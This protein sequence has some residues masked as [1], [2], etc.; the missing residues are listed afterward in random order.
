MLSEQVK[1]KKKDN[2]KIKK[3]VQT[4][5]ACG[6]SRGL[7]IGQYIVHSEQR[8]AATSAFNGIELNVS[9]LWKKVSNTSE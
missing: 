4:S 2:D 6:K 3:S 9:P 7:I 5:S 8:T 1:M